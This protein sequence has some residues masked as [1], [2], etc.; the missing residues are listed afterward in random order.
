M[1][2]VPVSL[3]DCLYSL[4]IDKDDPSFSDSKVRRNGARQ[5]RT[6]WYRVLR[7]K[8]DYYLSWFPKL[9]GVVV[10]CNV[11]NVDSATLRVCDGQAIQLLVVVIILG[12]SV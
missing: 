8:F 11:L 5:L 6:C 10:N 4:P 7:L 9:N 2:R 1:V 3:E 12:T